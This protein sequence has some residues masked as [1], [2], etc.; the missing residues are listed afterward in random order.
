MTQ[1]AQSTGPQ[2]YGEVHRR[3]LEDPEG[4]WLEAA[5]GIDWVRAPSRA[6]DDSRA[7]LYR[8]FPDGELNVCFNALDRHVIHGRGG[9]D[10]AQV[11]LPGH[12]H[13]ADV[14]LRPAPGRG[15]SV[16]RWVA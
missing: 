9:A 7:P 6:L 15:R 1:Q 5:Q 16:R 4:F 12:R 13:A 11:R 14:H 8:W 2:G 10:G 3:S